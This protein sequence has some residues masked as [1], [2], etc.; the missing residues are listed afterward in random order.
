[1][2]ANSVVPTDSFS[3]FCRQCIYSSLQKRVFGWFWL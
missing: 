2:L 3:I 1:M